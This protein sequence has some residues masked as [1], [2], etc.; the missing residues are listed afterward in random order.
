VSGIALFILMLRIPNADKILNRLSGV[1]ITFSVATTLLST[2]LIIYILKQRVSHELAGSDAPLTAVENIVE[3]SAIYSI[4]SIIWIPFR[5]IVGSHSPTFILAF[6][7]S[8]A[9]FSSSV[10]RFH[11]DAILPGKFLRWISTRT[12]PQV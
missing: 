9:F 12:L 11:R 4:A 1:N 6:A 10:V 2:I 8:S 7:V 5:M 3:S